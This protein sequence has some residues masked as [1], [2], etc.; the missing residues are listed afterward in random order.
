MNTSAIRLFAVVLFALLVS[1]CASNA[2][3]KRSSLASEV[4]V[5]TL[6]NPDA[7][8]RPSPVVI[9]V[10][11][12]RSLDRFQASELTAI[13]DGPANSL[14][15]D[16]VSFRQITVLPGETRAVELDTTSD[17]RFIAAVAAL[18]NYRSL[19]WRDAVEVGG[20]SLSK[21]FGSGKASIEVDQS[22]I[23]IQRQ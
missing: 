2:P 4:H 21:L 1:A 10:L 5:S 7:S 3:P 20:K 18:Q 15:A 14:G 17:T 22:G 6:A 16:L 19:Q 11:S 8:G 12:L 23:H 13:L 9:Y